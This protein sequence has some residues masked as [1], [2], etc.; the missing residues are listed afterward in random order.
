[1]RHSSV[2]R[3]H[4]YFQLT[5]DGLFIRTH[6][7]APMRDGDGRPV[8]ALTLPDGGEFSLGRV[9]LLLVLTEAPEPATPHHHDRRGEYDDE[10]APPD[11]LPASDDPFDAQPVLRR[12]PEK[13]LGRPIDVD[14]YFDVNDDFDRP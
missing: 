12:V 6:A 11:D 9:R 14:E 5:E 7:G 8:R 10:D 3:R 1:M 13:R 2:R 4:A